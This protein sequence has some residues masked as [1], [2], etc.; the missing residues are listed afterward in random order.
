MLR[1]DW[2]AWFRTCVPLG[3]LNPKASIEMQYGAIKSV[4]KRVVQRK[5]DLMS[6]R[7]LA[8]TLLVLAIHSVAVAA[9]DYD[10]LEKAWERGDS[11]E[12][13]RTEADNHYSLLEQM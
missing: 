6:M 11:P 1:N 13:L 4:P 8:L 3:L 5:K 2:W 10:A 12:E 7:R 9:I